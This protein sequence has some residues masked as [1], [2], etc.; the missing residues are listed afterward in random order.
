LNVCI[1]LHMSANGTDVPIA[2]TN[3]RCWGTPENLCSI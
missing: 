3:V 2:L 1:C